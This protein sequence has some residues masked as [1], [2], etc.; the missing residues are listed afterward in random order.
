MRANQAERYANGYA[1]VLFDVDRFKAYNDSAG[2][3]AGDEVLRSVA[4][5]LTHQ[6]RGGDSVYRYGGEELLV[7]LPEQDLD[8]ATVAAERMRREVEA[9]AIPHPGLGPP[10]AVVTVSGGVAS[11]SPEDA[12][13][14]ATLLE[15][16]DGGALQRKERGAQPNRRGP[17][18]AQ[19]AERLLEPL[20]DPHVGLPAQ[21]LMRARGVE[22]AV[23]HLAVALGLEVGLEAVPAHGGRAPRRCR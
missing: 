20:L 3:V 11:Y 14:V 2:H 19:R 7:V 6:R 4:A 21:H 8:G 5:A 1:V 15:R 10:P 22:R 9:L 23:P 17:P 18:L 13:N 12:G 16:A